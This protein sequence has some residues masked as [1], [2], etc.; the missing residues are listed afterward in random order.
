MNQPQSDKTISVETLGNEPHTLHEPSL[1]PGLL[2][3]GKYQILSVLGQGGMGTVYRVRQVMLNKELG[4]KMLDTRRAVDVAQQ[5]RRFHNEA[6]A[7]FSLNH[8]SLVKVHDLGVMESGEP[9][10]VMDIV[11][12]ISLNEHFKKSAPLPLVEIVPIFS[13]VCFALQYAHSQSVVHRDIK[14]GNI[15]LV[16]G[17]PLEQEG[18]VKVL[19]FGI[20]KIMGSEDGE[21]QALTRTGEVFGSPLYMSP[22]QCSGEHVD[23]RSDIYS[24]GCVLFEALTGTPPHVGANALRT[25]ML[26]QSDTTPTLSEASLGKKFPQGLEKIVAKMLEKNPA[27][28]YQDLGMVA[29]DLAMVGKGMTP[30]LGLRDDSKTFQKPKGKVVLSY[31]QLAML[32]ALTGALTIAADYMLRFAVQTKLVSVPI[33]LDIAKQAP[34]PKLPAKPVGDDAAKEIFEIGDMLPQERVKHAA[35][36]VAVFRKAAPIQAK[37]VMVGGARRKE[38]N[39]PG[40]PIGDISDMYCPKPH[41]WL[42]DATVPACGEV[43]EPPNSPLLLEVNLA[44]HAEALATPHIYDKIAPDIFSALRAASAASV[45]TVAA[46]DNPEAAKHQPANPGIVYLLK[47]AQ[48]WKDLHFVHL[49]WINV[50]DDLLDVLNTYPSLCDLSLDNCKFSASK[51]ARHELIGKLS[52]LNIYNAS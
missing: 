14:P 47:T 3:A 22:E 28:R 51:L 33:P 7:A 34:P 43:D 11:E 49:R 50:S 45:F 30:L 31:A 19:D 12:G 15:M 39:F 42:T 40:R 25:M 20:A 38:I 52:T 6:K 17:L 21:I 23:H 8:P 44:K 10:F 13:Q 18:S 2:I 48:K 32:L 16:R 37:F 24:L 1:N 29:T 41:V 26:H 36:T 4:L 35:E 5:E 27:D 46:T 9:Y